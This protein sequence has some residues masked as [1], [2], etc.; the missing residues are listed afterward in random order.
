MKVVFTSRFNRD[1]KTIRDP[2]LRSEVG[3]AIDQLLSANSISEV[4]QVKK[5]SGFE[6]AYRMKLGEYRIGFLL[7][8]QAVWLGRFG[9]R[10]DIYR[11]FP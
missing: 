9:H 8:G 5:L 4:K 2:S 1:L 10:K 7:V 3:A 6:N 11:R